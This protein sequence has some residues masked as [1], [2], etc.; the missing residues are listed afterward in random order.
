MAKADIECECCGYSEEW[1]ASRE[2]FDDFAERWGKHRKN[3]AEI[4]KANELTCSHGVGHSPSTHGCD[5]CCLVF[6]KDAEDLIIK[7]LEGMDK[8]IY[9]SNW[10]MPG[11]SITMASESPIS[12]TLAEAIAL[13]KGEQK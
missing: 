1:D 9:Y 2:D 4:V 10:V 5:G 3:H 7:L 13:I 8:H 6:Y 11:G 12:I